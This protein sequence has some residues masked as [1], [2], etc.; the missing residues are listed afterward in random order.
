MAGEAEWRTG[1]PYTAQKR[2]R[3]SMQFEN[4]T[5]TRRLYVTQGKTS[6][7]NSGRVQAVG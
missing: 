4:G 6:K 1:R 2:V 5:G 7:P 3:A